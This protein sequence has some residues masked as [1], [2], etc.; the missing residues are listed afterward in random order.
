MQSAR[1]GQGLA[2]LIVFLCLTF[3]L[4]RLNAQV[5]SPSQEQELS[6]NFY[7]NCLRS[8]GPDAALTPLGVQEI[9]RCSA[10][11]FS[12]K[13]PPQIATLLLEGQNTSRAIE[14]RER[15]TAQYCTNW[16]V[17]RQGTLPLGT[18]IKAEQ[19]TPIL[20]PHSPT[21]TNR[22]APSLDGS[23]CTQDASG[24]VRCSSGL[25][26]TLDAGLL[27]CNNGLIANTDQGGLTR[28]SDGSSALTDSSGLT[29]FS[30]G[31]TSQTDSS[32]LTRFSDGTTCTR[33][34]SGLI[35]CQAPYGRLK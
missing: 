31:T 27:K 11:T 22:A 1:T 34:G 16:I 29:R 30:D 21:D 33:D 13:V 18:L 7:A 35:R 9:C 2:L 4:P 17:D 12:T 10:V 25:I 14:D 3:H 26:C 19:I 20:V 32:G 6:R 5:L 8:F 15:A 24:L 28:F 23:T